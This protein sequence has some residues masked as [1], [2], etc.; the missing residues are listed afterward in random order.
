MSKYKYKG[1]DF[2]EEDVMKAAG[3][4]NLSF[5]DYVNKHKLEF[6]EDEV[7]PDAA[8]E[9]VREKKVPEFKSS[10]ISLEDLTVDHG[11]GMWGGFFNVEKNVLKSLTDHYKGSG[12]S[13][14]GVTGGIDEIEIKNKAGDTE[15]FA[16]P[17]T[18]NKFTWQIGG[19]DEMY[20]FHKKITDFIAAGNKNIDPELEKQQR[21]I[22][23]EILETLDNTQAMRNFIPDFTGNWEAIESD[24]D[25]EKKTLMAS[26]QKQFGEGTDAWYGENI[27]FVF[28][29]D[30]S[31]LSETDYQFALDKII[32]L[33]ASEQRIKKA[34]AKRLLEET[35][36]PSED[37]KAELHANR[38]QE[39]ISKMAPEEKKLVG[40]FKQYEDLIGVEGVEARE[41]RESLEKQMKVARKNLGNIFDQRRYTNQAFVL[42]LNGNY[43]DPLRQGSLP[44]VT[45]TEEE[46]EANKSLL[47]QK[48]QGRRDVIRDLSNTNHEKMYVSDKEGEK[49]DK[50]VIND[51]S[52]FKSLIRDH[53][54]KPIGKTEKGYIFELPRSLSANH[55]NYIVKG[56]GFDMWKDGLSGVGE[57]AVTGGKA[58]F[59][60]PKELT[61]DESYPDFQSPDG[62][63]GLLEFDKDQT[64]S[65]KEVSLGINPLIP[66]FV[67]G[68]WDQ[69]EYADNDLS[70]EYKRELKAWRDERKALV[71]DRKVL[72]DMHLLNIDPGSNTLS[73]SIDLDE[74]TAGE[75][76]FSLDFIPQGVGLLY[77]G[78]GHT[79]GFDSDAQDDLN[80]WSAR[81][82][83]DALDSFAYSSG[84]ELNA[85]QKE[86]VKRTGAYKVFEGVVGFVP[87]IIEFAAIEYAT[88][89]FG[90][91]TG[92]TRLGTRLT[93]SYKMGDKGRKI[94]TAQ[95]ANKI[96]YKGKLSDTKALD[97]AIMRWNLTSK[98][99]VSPYFP[100]VKGA[101]PGIVKGAG[102]T[103][104]QSA[105]FHGFHILKEEAKMAIAFEDDY[106][107]GMGAG[108]YIA[109]ASLPRFSF[110]R[111]SAF[112]QRSV[113]TLNA[114]LTMGRSGL[115]GATGT[116]AAANLEAFIEDIRGRTT[117]GKYLS[118]TYDD[119]SETGQQG[120]IDF[121]TFM[122]VGRGKGL[123]RQDFKSIKKL[124]R[125][126]RESGVLLK[127]LETQK[128]NNTGTYKSNRDLWNR[129]Y[130]KY[131]DLNK[132]VQITLN[133]I[134][135]NSKW[136][137]TSTRRKIV[138]RSSRNSENVI[139]QIPGME[140]FKIKI[141]D[142][143]RDFQNKDAVAEFNSKNEVF[144]DLSRIDKG[145]LPHEMGHVVFKALF[146]N[147]PEV[148]KMFVRE[149]KSSFKDAEFPSEV[150]K[151]VDGKLVGTGVM[152][153]MTLE[154][155]IK[156][157]YQEKKFENIKPEEF[158]TYTIE[159]LAQGKHYTKLVDSGAF[160]NLKQRINRFSNERNGKDIFSTSDSKQQLINFL[161]NFGKS[162]QKGS[163]TLEQVGMFKQFAT[164]IGNKK[165]DITELYKEPIEK[166]SRTES[167]K[168][169]AD[170]AKKSTKILR[171]KIENIYVSNI[172]GKTG[173]EKRKAIEDF[174]MGKNAKKGTPAYEFEIRSRNPKANDA[175]IKE[176]IEKGPGRIKTEAH[177][178]AIIMDALNKKYP[179]LTF[180][181]KKSLFY[182]LK[183][184][185]Y[186][187][188]KQAKKRGV[189]EAIM[190]YKEGKSKDL[191]SW[192]MANLLGSPEA[193]GFSRMHE[194]I[195]G[196]R[197]E[198]RVGNIE[199]PG[200]FR[201][202][203][204]EE[205]GVGVS[206]KEL[207][208]VTQQQ[209]RSAEKVYTGKK[210]KIAEDL[211]LKD[212][213]VEAGKRVIGEYME[214]APLKDFTYKKIGEAVMPI[215]RPIVER[216]FKRDAEFYKR[217]NEKGLRDPYVQEVIKAN[218][219]DLFDHAKTFFHSIPEQMSKMTA[220]VT[221][222]MGTFGALYTPT[223]KRLQWSEM[224]VWMELSKS[225]KASGPPIF[226]KRKV[227]NETE[228][229]K[230]LLDFMYTNPKTGKPLRT[231]QVNKRIER[232]LDFMTNSM[233]IQFA[234]DLIDTPGFREM[235]L[236]KEGAGKMISREKLMELD[237]QK[238]HDKVKE[239]LRDALPQALATKKILGSKDLAAY[240]RYADYFASKNLDW[241]WENIRKAHAENYSF[242]SLDV[243]LFYET[244]LKP[245]GLG[246]GE[247]NF[248]AML[249]VELIVDPK[250]ISKKP[251]RQIAE[252]AEL[253]AML[254]KLG[255]S[256]FDVNA[257][258]TSTAKQMAN[259]DFIDDYYKSKEG[260]LR[261]V[262]SKLPQSIVESAAFRYQFG[263]G[264]DGIA[265]RVGDLQRQ[266]WSKKK[267]K[268]VNRGLNKAAFNKLMK[269]GNIKGI[270]D[271]KYLKSLPTKTAAQRQQ[272]A[273]IA[274]AL[275]S[276]KITDNKDLKAEL[277]KELNKKEYSD[278]L[279][280]TNKQLKLK[281]HLRKFLGLDKGAEIAN[282]KVLE[283]F[284]F[285]V[286][287]FYLGAKNKTTALNQV[288][289]HLQSQTN[290]GRGFSRGAATHMD[291]SMEAQALG[292]LLRSEH[293]LQLI[294]FNT[295]FLVDVLVNGKNPKTFEKNYKEY[296]NI[297]RQ[298][299]ITE[300][301]RES[302]D[303]VYIDG[304][305]VVANTSIPEGY[306]FSHPAS[307]TYIKTMDVANKQL[308]LGEGALTKGQQ[309]T[310]NL[311]IGNI[312]KITQ[313]A[314][315]AIPTKGITKSQ[316]VKNLRTTDKAM[317]LGRMKDKKKR[318]MSTFDF[319]YT[320]GISENF[321]FATKGKE[322][323][324][325]SSAEW[326]FVGDKLLAE[327]W[328]MDF[329]DFNKVTK[330]KPGP[331]MQK[332]K[333][334]IKKF[335]SD[336][337]YILTARAPE[338]QKAIH[339]WLKS[340]GVN[341]PLKNIT[342]LGNSTGEAKA[343]W[344]LEKFSEGYNDMYFVDDALPNVKAVREVLDQLDIKSKVQQ[345]LPTKKILSD[346]FNKIIEDV[347]S[348]GAEKQYSGAKA[349]LLGE[350]KWTKSFITPANQDFAG[351]LRNFV[352]KGKKGEEHL[353]FFDE[354][355]HKP[356][357]RAY[358][359]LN[360][361]NQNTVGDFK[362]LA[363]N[364]PKVKKDLNKKIP[365]SPWTYDHAVRVHRWT[366]A[367]FK[368]PELSKTDIAELNKFVEQNPELL[369]F[370]EQL[371]SLTKLEKGYVEPGRDWV[372]GSIMSD[373]ARIVTSVNRKRELA[374]FM[375]NRE[376]I[377]GTWNNGKLEGANINK[378]EA[379][380]G[381]KFREA[382]EDIL[383]RME[384][385][386][387]RPTGKNAVVNAH[388]D[389]INGAVGTT[390]FLNSRSAMLQSLST[391]NYINWSFNNPAM[392]GKA[393][394]NQA[395]YWKDFKMIITSD[396]LRQRRGGLRYNVQEAELAQSAAR[397]RENWK[398]GD[399]IGIGKST[400]AYLLKK[401]FLPTQ[402]MDSFAISA[403]GA[404]FYRNRVN[405]L[406]K[407]G[408]TKVEAEKQAWLE[409]QEKTEVA[410]QS[411]RP[412]LIS[413][414]QAAPTGRLVLA[415][416]NTPMQYGRIQEKAVRDFI[417]RRGSQAENVSKILYYGGIQSA[418]FAGL[419]NAL[420]AFAL[421]EEGDMA[422]GD[423]QIPEK[424][425]RDKALYQRT[426][427]AANTVL[428]SQLRGIGIPGAVVGTLKNMALEFHA[429][430]KKE[431]NQDYGKVGL[432]AVSYSPPIGA[433]VRDIVGVG[434]TWKWNKDAIMSMNFF[435][436]DN[437]GLMA[438]A[439]TVQATTNLPTEATLQNVNNL[440]EAADW[441]NQW[442]QRVFS[443]IGFAPWDIGTEN[444]RYERIKK[445]AKKQRKKKNKRSKSTFKMLDS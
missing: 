142:N 65:G 113:A 178:D 286:K 284:N 73:I 344:M 17:S 107:I 64:F 358:N 227:F 275:K 440:R 296:A 320:V 402:V 232:G 443:A 361:A 127:I 436:L 316:M 250:K 416:A 206:E 304:K 329:S 312:K 186:L 133:R 398:K 380:Q 300:K 319:D 72:N 100:G 288:V 399:V 246:K 173:D 217:F 289:F 212:A 204:T 317:A 424:E 117:Y 352:G 274:K 82:S 34:E 68:W 194:I 91:A 48:T 314:G 136:A 132:H 254:K 405:D 302:V 23:A 71:N 130:E 193:G 188:N 157:E 141:K 112:G 155:Y 429:Q 165:V 345:A 266:S 95:M 281:E 149:L 38:D 356:F 201:K 347:Y 241:T 357:A 363:K 262:A 293:G 365:G 236:A 239:Q 57:K 118:E 108:F 291:V 285:A 373:L 273:E 330:G 309:I 152:K 287:D 339:D 109:G 221:G 270:P 166:D 21:N 428:D 243:K 422:K 362:A 384:T 333:N 151:L 278:I 261:V 228:L 22:E 94:S 144:L 46:Y 59:I 234:K 351:L 185:P 247:L 439:T 27:N 331:L 335:G 122:L 295:N 110:G 56:D 248:D 346:N 20:D 441:R 386:S 99:K 160:T 220:E 325:I 12:V 77:E 238:V 125:L 176:L 7:A 45:I 129:K 189:V 226:E 396:M 237:K 32:S 412:D 131:K 58:R 92:L 280:N 146:R 30:Y 200:M 190:D 308:Y 353:K 421:D 39:I 377:F 303:Y 103:T 418:V 159:L 385:G 423:P 269:D 374:E 297:Y 187:A 2:T 164:K 137:D 255:L 121:F 28:D 25:E 116:V 334:Q 61:G 343:M 231:E 268:M 435:D 397:G 147:N 267:G 52:V 4:A 156:N 408:A 13:M 218:R 445:K 222:A 199:I 207:G 419:Q 256:E 279:T 434:N 311:A 170:A 101:A 44:Q 29:G 299:V 93:T 50:V 126:E 253:P 202:S 401:G 315:F 35:Y 180:A 114:G 14:K 208:T 214:Q 233:G 229:K 390:M 158:I 6:V 37:F 235:I 392:A 410:Q 181:Q 340:E 338:S 138:E 387:N 336:N 80:L 24:D 301:V 349:K 322:K 162:I 119:L 404:T 84:F 364:F 382:L 298:G 242:Q 263:Q 75:S 371:G 191:A 26:L 427:R 47:E 89:G 209:Q 376:A 88:A 135:N 198:G 257:I 179:D 350:R 276:F 145:S 87:A 310:H 66:G 430:D 60:F 83:N 86:R 225:K 313:Q 174:L 359:N 211:K 139:R 370:S 259:K 413:Q 321:V 63:F 409:F 184:D 53:N 11:N 70:K 124:D 406:I 324:K 51:K 431:Y 366:R 432:Q 420:F 290:I 260:I 240:E 375:E 342:G 15:R 367:G 161:A 9:N 16:I 265:P 42:D 244:V 360:T 210:I 372:A 49:V 425:R 271:A 18:F 62:H 143:N 55:Y 195:K 341:I 106:K 292:K 306:T 140:N 272:K 305:R 183:H 318:G 54:I 407:K 395:Q 224:P 8:L 192:V 104:T 400:I 115:A 177:F 355:L 79:L 403:G 411:S 282:Q 216:A 153:K 394:A 327:G 368:V 128:R 90:T 283:L 76:D 215:L 154:E 150:K 98:S 223:G 251:V 74:G 182:E 230:A 433:R 120:L 41:K 437:P 36:L 379:T 442:W 69:D 393:F 10:H 105:M 444:E 205:K 252:W 196:E 328:K 96:G 354:N 381:P 148:T 97:E 383:W 31:K 67:G 369:E 169:T 389:F 307:A 277:V 123:T 378:I 391:F 134:D 203:I 417:N 264:V 81:A 111:E 323:R 33:K 19:T 415:W 249:P 219:R 332:L 213:E 171:D 167:E 172:A 414:N 348:I 438:A 245:F 3:N 5:D 294:N 175:K 337:V 1:T 197:R 168:T 258:I 43:I 102:R 388:M 78:F 426:W 163:L 40:L 85:E 326:P